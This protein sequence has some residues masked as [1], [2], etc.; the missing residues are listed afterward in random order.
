LYR[1]RGLVFDQAL[2][3]APFQVN[4]DDNGWTFTVNPAP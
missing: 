4:G 3:S 1:V 2:N